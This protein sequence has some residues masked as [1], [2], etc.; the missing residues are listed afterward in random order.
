MRRK[1]RRVGVRKLCLYELHNFTGIL[2]FLTN[3]LMLM[4]YF[5][6]TF[7]NPNSTI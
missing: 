4:T 7:H 1:G 6:S 2:L 3:L 5:I